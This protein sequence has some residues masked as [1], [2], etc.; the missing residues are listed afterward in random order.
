MV[1]ALEAA[2]RRDS[3]LAQVRWSP[4]VWLQ[5]RKGCET[6]SRAFYIAG[7]LS[8]PAI[9]PD[10]RLVHSNSPQ[11]SWWGTFMGT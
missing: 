11:A 4:R 5:S 6:S 2:W 8:S 9:H 7:V 3:R 1:L 10:E